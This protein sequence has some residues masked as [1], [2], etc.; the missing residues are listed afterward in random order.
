MQEPLSQIQ[1]YRIPEIPHKPNPS[2]SH[3]HLQNPAFVPHNVYLT[4]QVEFM[5]VNFQ[6]EGWEINLPVEMQDIDGTFP[7]NAKWSDAKL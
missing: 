7:L 2:T 1:S 6:G 5:H 3:E 4:L